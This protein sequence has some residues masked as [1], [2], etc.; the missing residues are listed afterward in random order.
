VCPILLKIGKLQKVFPGFM[1]FHSYS[2]LVNFE[3]C[4]VRGAQ[5]IQNLS[6]HSELTNSNLWY[7]VPIMDF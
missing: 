4:M 6:T 3:I 2:C 5:N 1:T 7:P